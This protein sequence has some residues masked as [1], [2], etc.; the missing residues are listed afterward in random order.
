MAGITFGPQGRTPDYGRGEFDY[1]AIDGAVTAQVLSRGNAMIHSL[2]VGAAG[3]SL[4]LLEDGV[5]IV[6]V[7]TSTPSS[8]PMVL[9]IAVSGELTVTTVGSGTKA[10]IAYRGRPGPTSKILRAS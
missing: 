1:A 5:A 3:T 9:D 4:T 7:D 2:V 10:T 8:G 6:V